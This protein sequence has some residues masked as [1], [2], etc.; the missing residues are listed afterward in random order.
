MSV[1]TDNNISVNEYNKIT[2]YKDLEIE[3]EKIWHL[4]TNIMPVTVWTRSMNNKGT[5]KHINKIPGNPNRYEM[6]KIDLCGTA[7]LIRRVLSMCNGKI[8]PKRGR[9]KKKS[10]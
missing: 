2:K 4:K 3:I 6:Q 10:K 5:D 7:H 9:K 1:P 8:T